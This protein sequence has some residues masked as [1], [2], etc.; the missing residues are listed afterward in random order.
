MPNVN[1][2]PALYTWFEES[3]GLLDEALSGTFRRELVDEAARAR[4]LGEALM[5]L[6]DSMR[7]NTWA[8]DERRISLRRPIHELETVTRREGLHAL[9]DWDGI[10]DKVNED[11]IAVDVLHYLIEHRGQEPPDPATLAILIDYYFVYL[12]GLL[13]LRAWDG[14]DADENLDRLGALLARLQGANGSGQRFAADAETLLLV[15]TSHYELNEHGYD[16]LLER[17]RTLNRAHRLTIALEHAVSMGCH[18]RFGF[19]ATYAR[20]VLLTRDDNVADYPW[21]CFSVAMLMDEYHR[22]HEAGIE[23]PERDVI[24]EGLLNGLSGDARAFV[25]EPPSSL[26]AFE[27]ERST[28]RDRFQAYRDDLLARFEPFRPT[29]SAYS[30]LSFFFNFSHNVIKGIVIDALI[31]GE[32]WRLSLNDLLTGAAR[33]E[34]EDE[35]RQ[36]LA[37]TLMTYARTNPQRI[38]GKLMPVIVYDPRAG[39]QAF[40]VTVRRLR[41]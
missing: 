14:G 7:T 12:L 33:E 6:R 20:D 21:L 4:T 1:T 22:L 39:R 15:A 26:A 10:A 41:E 32:P 18:L 25:G 36:L 19:E 8:L 29:D 38:R 2:S 37:R 11:T 28:F 9:H 3:C 27:A 13:S 16:L 34:A 23:G 40:G 24:V 17:T 31:W 5:K 30:P 35:S